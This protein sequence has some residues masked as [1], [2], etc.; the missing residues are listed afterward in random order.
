MLYV[1][2]KYIGSRKS[3]EWKLFTHVDEVRYPR[4]NVQKLEKFYLF[5]RLSVLR[6]LTRQD[7][8][9]YLFD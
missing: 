8:F 6:D 5:S 9:R 2:Y 7:Q 3:R 1:I 4:L